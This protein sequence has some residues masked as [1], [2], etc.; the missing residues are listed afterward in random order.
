VTFAEF[1]RTPLAEWEDEF[2]SMHMKLPDKIKF[3]SLHSENS[4]GH[5]TAPPS[6][7]APAASAPQ[8]RLTQGDA[9][10]LHLLDGCIQRVTA[11]QARMATRDGD[12][13]FLTGNFTLWKALFQ[14]LQIVPNLTGLAERKEDYNPDKLPPVEVLMIWERELRARVVQK[15]SELQLSGLILAVPALVVSGIEQEA[16]QRICSYA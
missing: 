3:R 8:A 9:K 11:L 4:K 5:A 13:K 2:Q 1:L 15:R 14:N 12:F 6:S 7:V 16:A 10:D